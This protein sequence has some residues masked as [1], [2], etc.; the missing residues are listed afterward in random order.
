MCVYQTLVLYMLQGPQV[1]HNS[2]LIY[3]GHH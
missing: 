1:M 2:N 3:E